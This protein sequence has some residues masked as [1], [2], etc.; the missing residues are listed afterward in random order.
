MG[1]DTAFVIFLGIPTQWK[2]E[3]FNPE[4]VYLRRGFV[5]NYTVMDVSS[6]KK[7]TPC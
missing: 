7:E 6:K 5:Y 2:N 4:G 1:G 3:K